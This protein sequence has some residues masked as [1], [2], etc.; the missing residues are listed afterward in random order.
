[1]FVSQGIDTCFTQ[2]LTCAPLCV[3]TPLPG[4]PMDRRLRRVT[5][6]VVRHQAICRKTRHCHA[7]FYARRAHWSFST[8]EPSSAFR[9]ARERWVLASGA[10]LLALLTLLGIPA[11]AKLMHHHTVKP[12]TR[13]ALALRLP[14]APR[15]PAEP[16]IAQWKAVEVQPG[17]TLSE[18]FQAQGLSAADLASVMATA[19][20]TGALTGL[21]PGD[22]LSFRIGAH[23]NLEGFRYY[24]DSATRVTLTAG[25][26]GMQSQVAELPVENRLEFA[27]GLVTGSLAAASAKAGLP[28]GIMLKLAKVFRHEINFSRD[29]KKGDRFTIIY[30]DVYRNGRFVR[31]GDIVAAEFD[32]DGHKYTAYRFKKADGTVAYYSA[33]G[34]PL[35]SALLRV[36]V[37]YTRISSP[38]GM[39]V[40]PITHRYQLHAGVDYAAPTGTP[41][42]AAG[43]GTI[44]VH[45]WVHGFGNMVAV[46]NTPVYTT[47]YGH[48]SRFAPGLHVGSHVTQG[49]VIGYVGQTGYA[50]GPHL[51]YEVLV[52]GRPENPLTV[53][54]PKPQPLSGRMM[55]AFKSQTAP[56]VA[57]IQMIDDATQ[58]LA[59][60]DT[61]YT[62]VRAAD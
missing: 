6:H 13:E 34:R 23:G 60:V 21:R 4:L 57:R 58:R 26:D 39:R 40:D 12:A 29:V 25:K 14:P 30:D 61:H 51:H 19:T 35:L 17:Q 31:P 41:I 5:P 33:R 42:H 3:F 56:L 15:E 37:A 28:T 8:G 36:P 53:T 47:E 2:T 32:N 46:K 9:W 54:M 7:L 27:H 48:M 49:E 45:G 44:T 18:I 11:W 59:R 10:C 62:D 24:T 50:T 52:D 22:K 38:F 43:S 16:A 20:D 1:M 55:A